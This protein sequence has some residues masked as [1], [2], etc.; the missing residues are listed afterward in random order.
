MTTDTATLEVRLAEAKAAL[1]DL[2]V[3]QQVT[4]VGYDGHRTEFAPGDETRL[5]RYIATLKRQLGQTVRR[6]GSSPV[7]F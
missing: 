5:R 2:M 4:V 7:V 3:G 1:H 6:P